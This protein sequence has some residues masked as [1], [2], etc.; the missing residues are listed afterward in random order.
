MTGSL[1]WSRPLSGP[2]DPASPA[3]PRRLPPHRKAIE[4]LRA[5]PILV[6]LLLSPGIPEYL[7][8]SSPLNWIV[9]LPAGFVLQLALNLGL[10]G[11]GVL[12]VRE[13]SVRWKKRGMIPV[14]L[15]GGAYGILEEGIALST[16]FDPRASVVHSLGIYG[17]F[18]GVNTVWTAGIL[19]VHMVYSIGLPIFLLGQAIPATRGRPLLTSRGVGLALGILS[20]DVAILLL[21]VRGGQHFWMGWSLFVGSFAAI[22]ALI[23]LAHAW[24]STSTVRAHVTFDGSLWIPGLAG[25]VLFP[26]IL[27]VEGLGQSWGVPAAEV[28]VVVVS[29]QLAVGLF[30]Y[31]SLRGGENQR[32]QLVFAFGLLLPI[33][34]IGLVAQ[35]PVE[36]VLIADVALVVW[37]SRL[38]RSAGAGEEPGRAGP[39]LPSWLG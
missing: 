23:L 7:S 21:A 13:A 38:L 35:F 20:I 17:H 9:L 8:G 28:I 37:L 18:D 33:M 16:L 30:A 19:M 34:A 6:L 3:T 26:G 5:R 29:M 12:L 11:P 36:I 24:P 27:V 1:P 10:Y 31:R 4:Y 25:A 14:L 22:A 2:I 39:P 32:R 15:L